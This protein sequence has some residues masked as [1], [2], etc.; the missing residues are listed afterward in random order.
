MD[1]HGTT[2]RNYTMH[3]IGL[4]LYATM[5]LS[6]TIRQKS[7][8]QPTVVGILESELQSSAGLKSTSILKT[9]ILSDKKCICTPYHMCKNNNGTLGGNKQSNLRINTTPCQSYLD[10]CCNDTKITSTEKYKSS[11]PDTTDSNCKCNGSED[12]SED[13]NFFLTELTLELF[14]DKK[15]TKKPSVGQKDESVKKP[16][17]SDIGDNP[18]EP[19]NCQKGDPT[20]T[21]LDS[22]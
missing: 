14:G 2:K 10:V 12:Y 20:E 22:L 13:V 18:K 15:V 16:F 8:I 4:F 6:S 9:T 11:S 21:S 7:I 3:I 19:C 1:S 5:V 17:D